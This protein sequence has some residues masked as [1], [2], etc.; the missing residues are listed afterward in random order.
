MSLPISQPTSN[1]GSRTRC[2]TRIK[3]IHVECNA[4]T[5]TASRCNRNSIVHARCHPSLINFAHGKEAHAQFS[6]QLALAGI[7]IS[8]PNMC[9][10]PGIKFWTEACDVC[11]FARSEAEQCC[12]RHSVN[13]S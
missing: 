13:V 5:C 9:A 10:Q 11:E 4:I 8:R 6:Y 2:I 7:D 3:S 1:K 12:E